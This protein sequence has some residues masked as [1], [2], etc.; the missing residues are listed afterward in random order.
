[1]TFESSQVLRLRI[2]LGDSIAM[3]PGKA[4]LLEAI[5]SEGSISAAGRKLGM[6]YRK[7]WLLMDQMN[8]GFREPLVVSLKGG[9]HG[10]GAKVTAFGERVL[11]A[12]RAMESAAWTVIQPGLEGLGKLLR[13][14]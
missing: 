8:Q 2:P 13:V 14:P 10:G 1:M 9:A 11:T 5:R 3:G 12:Y 4:A 7:A 6:S